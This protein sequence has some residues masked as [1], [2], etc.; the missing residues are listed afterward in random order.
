MIYNFNKHQLLQKQKMGKGRDTIWSC[1]M[2]K[3]FRKS[4]L[5]LFCYSKK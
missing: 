4:L 5:K 1:L 2:V 3:K